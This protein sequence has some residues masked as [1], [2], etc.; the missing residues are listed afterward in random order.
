M[1][2]QPAALI[3]QRIKMLLIGA[4]TLPMLM[5]RAEGAPHLT[6]VLSSNQITRAYQL[7]QTVVRLEPGEAL[8][9]DCVSSLGESLE[10]GSK[11]RVVTQARDA[12]F[13]QARTLDSVHFNLCLL[14]ASDAKPGFNDTRTLPPTRDV[15][16]D[17]DDSQP[18]RSFYAASRDTNLHREQRAC[19]L[20]SLD[21]AFSELTNCLSH[22]Q[23]ALQGSDAPGGE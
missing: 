7:C 4:L 22:L 3:A 17:M 13:A 8:F 2:V 16:S 23:D 5:V 9:N 11:A 18:S 19:A 6:D 1:I 15:P 21:P 10:S 12:C 20:L 14:R